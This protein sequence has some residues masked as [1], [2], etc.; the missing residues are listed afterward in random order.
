MTFDRQLLFLNE[1]DK[2]QGF[3]VQDD[4][5]LPHAFTPLYA[6]F[7]TVAMREGTLKAFETLKMPIKQFNTKIENGY[8]YQTTPPFEGDMQARME[9]HKQVVG[10]RFPRIRLICENYVENE[11]LPFYAKLEDWGSKPFTAADAIA[12][13]EELHAFYIRAWELHFEIVLPRAS[14]FMTLEDLYSKLNGVENAV[15]VY[16]WLVG[17]MNKSLETDRELWKLAKVARGSEPV[18]TV[19][20]KTPVDGLQSE[21][22]ASGEGRQFLEQLHDFLQEYGYRSTNAHE[23]IEPAW[24]EEPKPALAVISRYIKENYNFEQEFHELLSRRKESF[25]AAIQTWPEGELKQAF[26]QIYELALDCAGLDEDHHFY[27]DAMLPTKSRLFLLRIGSFLVKQ[28]VIHDPEDIFFFYLDEVM[29]ALRNPVPSLALIQERRKEYGQNKNTKPVPTY[30]KPPQQMETDLVVERVFGLKMPEVEAQ[31]FK[32]YAASQGVYTGQVR[33]VRSPE[34]FNKV[35][36]GEIL[37]CKTTTPAWTALF[38]LVGAII[39]DAGGI[40]SHAGTVAREY[41]IPAVLG[42]KVATS[43]VQDGQTV[44]V[45]GTQGIVTIHE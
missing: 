32:G 41:R 34:D 17:V 7:Q 30:G 21:L 40:L 2:Q 3:W 8:L 19:F 36:K 9:Q 18:L 4:V 42:T 22:A 25:E 1:Q 14:L 43:L 28:G 27:I 39:T 38:S 20:E 15:V 10:E 5:H 24:V 13:I 12:W 37:V 31:T 44:T 29:E 11:F 23:F 35:Q 26:L 6:C 33:V 45:D 16:E